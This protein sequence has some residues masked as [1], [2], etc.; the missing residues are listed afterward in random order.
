MGNQAEKR[1]HE[2]SPALIFAR[3][4]ADRVWLGPTQRLALSQLS[5]QQPLIAL[6]GP[7]ASGRTTLL[8]RSA[9]QCANEVE[10]LLVSGRQESAHSLLQALMLSAGLNCGGLELME[11]RQLLDVFIDERLSKHGRLRIAVDDA[12]QLPAEAFAEIARLRQS[13]NSLKASPELLMSLIDAEPGT[14]ASD[15]LRSARS[16]GIV[17]LT[18]LSSN[19]VNWYLSW[20]LER[21]DL[22][23][24]ITPSAV[25]QIELC[26][27]GCFS[28]INHICQLALLLM[29]NQK[30]D[31]VD[32]EIVQEAV[33][34]HTQRAAPRTDTKDGSEPAASGSSSSA[35]TAA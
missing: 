2:V 11:L 20:R 1:I 23:G 13:S 15:F 26:T 30:A 17:V 21:Y 34:F 12:D 31:C 3:P 10:T 5:V 24:T 32:S 6:L 19:E 14:P 4:T 25:R 33:R 28:S 16:P 9:Y 7:R 18:W 22:I 27:R 35:V 29:R 8:Q